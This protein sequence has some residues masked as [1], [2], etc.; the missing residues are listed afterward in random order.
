MNIV[1]RVN[2][3]ILILLIVVNVTLLFINLFRGKK[4]DENKDK[5]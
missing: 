2:I 1:L 3:V 5:F 4:R